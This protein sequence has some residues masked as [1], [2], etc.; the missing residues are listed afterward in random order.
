M[1]HAKKKKKKVEWGWNTRQEEGLSKANLKY[2]GK[3]LAESEFI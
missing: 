3:Q 2:V 1:L